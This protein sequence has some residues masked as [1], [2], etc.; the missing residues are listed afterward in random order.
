MAP[1][2][3]PWCARGGHRQ[4]PLVPASSPLA[5]RCG[6]NHPAQSFSVA[7]VSHTANMMMAQ[8]RVFWSALGPSPVCGC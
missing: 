5:Y 2:R 4:W 8:T 6:H 1:T 7:I 3:V